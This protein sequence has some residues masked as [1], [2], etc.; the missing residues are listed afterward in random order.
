M[1]SVGLLGHLLARRRQLEAALKALLY[2]EQHPA[3][4]ARDKTYNQPLLAELRSEL[5]A[6]FEQA[7]TWTA[8]QPLDDMVRWLLYGPA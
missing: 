8:N 6:L 5:P 3:S 4:L 1:N 2:V 7:A